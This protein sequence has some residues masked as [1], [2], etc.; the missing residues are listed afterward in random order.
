MTR[1]KNVVE[2]LNTKLGQV[3]CLIKIDSITEEYIKDF[4]KAYDK[5]NELYFSLLD[6]EKPL[7]KPFLML[8]EYAKDVEK[9]YRKV[10]YRN[11]LQ[12]AAVLY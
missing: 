6:S 9:A 10:L 5:Y 8:T 4:N 3:I 12:P 1:D 2:S 11:G 7:A